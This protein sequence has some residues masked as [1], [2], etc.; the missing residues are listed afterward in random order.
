MSYPKSMQF[1]VSRL[2]GFSKQGVKL[3]P[4]SQQSASP[5]DVIVYELPANTVI[6]LRTLSLFA[7]G[8]TTA[9]GGTSPSV[10]FPKHIETLIDSI[11]VEINGTLVDSGFLGY[12]QLH[13]LY[14]DYLAGI[15]KN[16]TMRSLLQQGDLTALG[17]TTTAVTAGGTTLPPVLASA[18]VTGRTHTNLPIVFNSFLGF[19]S[20]KCPIIDTSILGQVR[21]LV[22]LAPASVLLVS[23]AP[24][25]FNYSLSSMFATIDMTRSAR[26]GRQF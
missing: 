24:T 23:G 20:A 21:V 22:K 16:S 10:V 4:M 18:M 9:T 1:A 14:M 6:D 12:N 3:R 7:L 19:L 13:K 25:S 2:S 15:D 11:Q 8:T 26:V 5:G 17:H